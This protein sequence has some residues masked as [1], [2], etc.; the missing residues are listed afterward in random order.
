MP[1]Q[2][3]NNK[4]F[5]TGKLRYKNDLE[6]TAKNELKPPTHFRYYT[7]IQHINGSIMHA[8]VVTLIPNGCYY[9]AESIFKDI[10]FI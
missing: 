7:S 3:F 8:N 5:E 10:L 1:I 2:L 9:F 6:C 4:V